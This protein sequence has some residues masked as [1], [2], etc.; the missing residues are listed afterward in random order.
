MSQS[1]LSSSYLKSCQRVSKSPMKKFLESPFFFIDIDNLV[2]KGIFTNSLFSCVCTAC[3]Q[4]K[5]GADCAQ[6]CPCL[7]NGTCDRFTGSCSCAAGFYGHSCQ[8]GELS[9]THTKEREEKKKTFMI[10]LLELQLK[11]ENIFFFYCSSEL[12]DYNRVFL[13][14]LSVP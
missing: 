3:S 14:F 9:C 11:I 5:Y 4:E 6:D 10:M 12:D 7:N 13:S 2:T 8:H 1:C